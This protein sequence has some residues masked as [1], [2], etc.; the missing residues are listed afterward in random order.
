[1]SHPRLT[2]ARTCVVQHLEDPSRRCSMFNVI[3][4][5]SE[6]GNAKPSFV[7]TLIFVKI[8]YKCSFEERLK[9]DQGR[10][11][12]AGRAAGAFQS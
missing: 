1:M 11:Q 10:R 12:H 9:W 3:I 5:A 6:E 2:H 4:S 7:K 8:F